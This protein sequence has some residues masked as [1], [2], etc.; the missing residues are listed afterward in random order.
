MLIGNQGGLYWTFCF[1]FYLFWIYSSPWSLP[2]NYITLFLLPSGILLVSTN[3]RLYQE[4]VKSLSRVWL[5]ATPWTVAY[6]APL[7]MG[8]SRQEYWSELPLPSPGE[9]SWP[10]DQTQVSCIAGRCFNL[11]ATREPG[12]RRQNYQV[13]LSATP[14]FPPSQPII[15]TVTVPLCVSTTI[16][17]AISQASSITRDGG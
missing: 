15:L 4:K 12:K 1:Y 16:G 5:F 7:S 10:R 3:R 11:W 6:Q 2:Q 14:Q 17:Q 8:F 9:S 13:Q